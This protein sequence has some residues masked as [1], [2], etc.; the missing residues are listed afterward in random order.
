MTREVCL[1]YRRRTLSVL[2][3]CCEDEQDCG[4]PPTCS[5]WMMSSVVTLESLICD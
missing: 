2:S 3:I 4:G 1:S 5:P